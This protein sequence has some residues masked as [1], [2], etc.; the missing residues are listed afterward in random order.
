M[1]KGGQREALCIC[2]KSMQSSEILFW[3]P[4]RSLK[5]TESS[6]CFYHPRASLFEVISKLTQLT[7]LSLG[8]SLRGE[9]EVPLEVPQLQ[10]L[11]ALLHVDCR[12]VRDFASLRS[13][14]LRSLT[15]WGSTYG[16]EDG[17]P[18]TVK[19][20]GPHDFRIDLTGDLGMPHQLN[21][22]PWPHLDAKKRARKVHEG[23][24]Y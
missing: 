1:R 17:Y 15:L 5:L 24:A 20:L 22:R 18:Q 4:R 16:D 21:S 19:D 13:T 14:T 10:T 8:L 23:P 6:G 2:S 3:R 7:A 12:P 9:V 11:E